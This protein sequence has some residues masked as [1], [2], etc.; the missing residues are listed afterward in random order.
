[1]YQNGAEKDVDQAHLDIT[2]FDRLNEEQVKVEVTD[3]NDY[4]ARLQY[5]P[6]LNELDFFSFSS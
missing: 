2:Y 4:E 3:Y 1:M 5:L 6:S